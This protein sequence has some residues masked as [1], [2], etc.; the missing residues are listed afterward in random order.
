MPLSK[1]ATVRS[2]PDLDLRVAVYLRQEAQLELVRFQRHRAEARAISERAALQVEQD[3]N[4]GFEW[5]L[6]FESLRRQKRSSYRR[7][8]TPLR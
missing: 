5:D 7:I 2:I 3:Q 8:H 4:I 6:S 1:Q